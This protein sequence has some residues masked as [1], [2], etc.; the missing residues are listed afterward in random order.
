MGLCLPIRRRWLG[1]WCSQVVPTQPQSFLLC[2]VFIFIIEVVHEN[3]YG[4]L[5][6]NIDDDMGGNNFCFSTVF[7]AWIGVMFSNLSI[8]VVFCTTCTVND[9]IWTLS[10][11]VT[12]AVLF[13]VLSVSHSFAT[14]DDETD[15]FCDSLMATG[16][17]C[18]GTSLC[19]HGKIVRML[20]SKS[21]IPRS[22]TAA[23]F[24]TMRKHAWLHRL[25]IRTWNSTVLVNGSVC[26][27]TVRRLGSSWFYMQLLHCAFTKEEPTK[28]SA[29]P[30]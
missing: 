3:V 17:Y 23:R 9:A 13:V 20:R 29:A 28:F 7:S 15:P 8:Y 22:R 6:K 10:G 21:D 1:E 4:L 18:H 2:E 11:T 27:L 14:S 26:L 25:L 16:I 19:L 5:R 24:S 30:V 12:G